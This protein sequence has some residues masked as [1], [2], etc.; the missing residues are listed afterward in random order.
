[1]K[2]RLFGSAGDAP[3]AYARGFSTLEI[4]IAFAI[5]TLS[6]TAV[7]MVVFGNQSLAVDTETNVEA[8]GKAQA[9]LE[10]TRANARADFNSV[11]STTTTETSGPLFYTKTLAVADITQC[12]KQATGIVSWQA[13]SR[14]LSISL[15]THLSDIAGALALGGDCPANPPSGDWSNPIEQATVDVGKATGIDVGYTTAFVTL[16]D[17]PFSGPDLAIVD[18]TSGTTPVVMSKTDWNA[19]PGFN[20]IDVATSTD[21]YLYAY[22]ARN[23]TSK[24]LQIINVSS[25][26]NP[27]LVAST[28]LPNMTTGIPRS[29][30]Y[31][32]GRVYIGTQYLA[33]VGCPASQNNELHIFDVTDPTNP[34]WEDSIKINRN[35][36]AVAVRNGLVYLATGSGS[37]GVHNPLKA[38]NIDPSSPTY[39]QQVGSFTATGNE[40]GTALFFIGNKLYLG[41]EKAT[42]ER[43]E[44]FILD[45]SQPSSISTIASTTLNLSSSASVTGIRV[46]GRY[47]FLGISDPTDGLQVRD[48]SESTIDRI[49]TGSFNIQK[50][51]TGIDTDNTA[52]YLS[53][54]SGS[55]N[56]IIV[57]PTP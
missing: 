3:R 16:S 32:S 42:S 23:A 18:V 15:I 2:A 24:Q 21:G 33:C 1:M 7:I 28:T 54:N 9:L 39:K 56:F 49:N 10:Q 50:S 43:P 31:Y 19:S 40:Q 26:T 20:A 35:V 44:F 6:M 47:A 5:L 53:S 37:A 14:A 30:F 29:I 38:F 41:L 4:L 57:E 27:V 25:S 45:I 17:I 52:V 34:H 46:A 55:T 13:G 8:L 11:N 12:K 48:I 51:V 22:I 36:N